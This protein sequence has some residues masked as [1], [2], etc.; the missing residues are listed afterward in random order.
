KLFIDR[1]PIAETPGDR[2]VWIGEMDGNGRLRPVPAGLQPKV[3]KPKSVWCSWCDGIV[4]V[5][6]AVG[7]HGAME[8][9]PRAPVA[10][11]LEHPVHRGWVGKIRPTFIM[12]HHVIAGGIIRMSQDRQ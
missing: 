11:R 12:D 5:T 3:F 7:M 10:M 8:I 2:A 9:D 6:D 4:W 1:R